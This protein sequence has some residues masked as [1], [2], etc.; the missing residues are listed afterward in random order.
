[1]DS[2]DVSDAE[3]EEVGDEVPPPP[4]APGAPCEQEWAEVFEADDGDLLVDG[5]PTPGRGQVKLITFE[6]R[7]DP[8][9]DAVFRVE[10]KDK[11]W[12]LQKG[13]LA[14]NCADPRRFRLEAQFL[15]GETCRF[16][17]DYADLSRAEQQATINW[18]LMIGAAKADFGLTGY[19]DCKSSGFYFLLHASYRRTCW[20]IIGS[21]HTC[22]LEDV[23]G[24]TYTCNPQDGGQFE[25]P[26]RE[27]QTF[28]VEL[29]D[30]ELWL[31]D[32]GARVLR[33]NW[34][35]GEEDIEPGKLPDIDFA[36]AILTPNCPTAFRASVLP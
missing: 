2:P 4:V 26:A 32:G 20:R 34:K 27:G 21:P 3:E 22:E 5:R 1:M 10:G 8:E 6:V 25:L 19:K 23:D 7:Q 13:A 24:R 16:G 36:P 18:L 11:S 35:F 31:T 29:C 33:G 12:F 14:F 17:D 28:G 9:D 30:G 15:G